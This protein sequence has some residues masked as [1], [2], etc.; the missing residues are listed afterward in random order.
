VALLADSG[1]VQ[2]IEST[3]ADAK[4][5]WFV[6]GILPSCDRSFLH[7]HPAWTSFHRV[8]SDAWILSMNAYV[9]IAI[10]LGVVA[11]GGVGFYVFRRARERAVAAERIKLLQQMQALAMKRFR[12]LAGKGVQKIGDEVLC[13]LI[14]V[15]L[16]E[17]LGIPKE[18]W[19][20]VPGD[21][22]KTAVLAKQP[23]GEFLDRIAEMPV[24]AEA[25]RKAVGKKL[26][27]EWAS[28]HDR[29]GGTEQAATIRGWAKS[30]GY[31]D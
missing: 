21:F 17:L 10:A 15:R 26:L 25:E 20:D 16:Q 1:A 28:A 23:I 2:K 11:G 24:I 4:R 31:A 27:E 3:N 14:P 8:V 9:Y 7:S 19:G 29:I 22:M 18:K 30:Q 12:T 5:R 13:P 6:Y